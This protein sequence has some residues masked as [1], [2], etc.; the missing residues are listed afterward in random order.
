MAQPYVGEIQAFAFPWA[1]GGIAPGWLPCSGQVLPVQRFASLFALIGTIYGGNGT[2]N[3]A[4]PNLNGSVTN[5][6]GTGPGLTPRVIG[7]TLGSA[8][9]SLMSDEMARHTHT[10][11]LGSSSAQGAEPGPGAGT[12]MV[13]IDPAFTGAVVPP[14][15]TVLS[16]NAVTRTGQGLPHDNMQPSL[17]IVWC[18]ASSGIYPRFS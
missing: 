1:S 2:T 15:T 10:L 9:V 6:Q 12:N 7:E 18:I 5:S 13:A 8:T 4:L 3:F 11:Q 17:A 14:A 16:P